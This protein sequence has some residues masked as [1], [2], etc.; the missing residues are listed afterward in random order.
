MEIKYV[1]KKTTIGLNRLNLRYVPHVEPLHLYNNDMR[2]KSSPH[3][4]MLH[5]IATYGFDWDKIEKSRYVKILQHKHIMGIK[6]YDKES[7]L[8]NL[9]KAWRTY[10]SIAK[11]GLRSRQGVVILNKPFWSTRFGYKS[12]HTK[13]MEIWT[14]VWICAAALFHGLKEVKG[15]IAEDLYPGSGAKGP[16]EEM[17]GKVDGVFDGT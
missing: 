11:R 8:K 13:G 10:S 15:R 17:Y 1:S 16:F 9:N 2:L 6:G 7:V 14:G 4:E 5:I 3:L 12:E